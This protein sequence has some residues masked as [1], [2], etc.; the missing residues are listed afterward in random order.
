MGYV[1]A[2]GGAK[3][4][5]TGLGVTLAAVSYCLALIARHGYC[6]VTFTDERKL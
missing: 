5:D 1:V 2:N 6:V 3:R 4:T